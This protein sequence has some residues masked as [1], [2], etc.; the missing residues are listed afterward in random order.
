MMKCR[1]DT[2]AY[3]KDL[4]RLV[5]N[6]CHNTSILVVLYCIKVS[7]DYHHRQPGLALDSGGSDWLPLIDP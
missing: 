7:I 1:R 5:T 6:P 3:I 2:T 4:A